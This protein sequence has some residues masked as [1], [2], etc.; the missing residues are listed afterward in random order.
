MALTPRKIAKPKQK[1][2]SLRK[3]KDYHPRRSSRIMSLSKQKLNDLERRISSDVGSFL[4][5]L[6]GGSAEQVL[7]ASQR[8][9]A[10]VLKFGP[11]MKK[12]AGE[13]GGNFPKLLGDFLES[14]DNILH[15][16]VNWID[17]AKIKACYS[18]T[19]KFE[20]ALRSRLKRAHN[21]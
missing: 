5:L 12:L 17:E 1:A 2:G 6:E 3:M 20:Q 10:D 19:Q 9:R 21:S 11:D 7:S 14:I 18:T 8:A 15:T 13:L 16:G 4:V